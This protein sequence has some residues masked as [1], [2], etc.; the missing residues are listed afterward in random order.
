M[1]RL[2]YVVLIALLF[3]TAC[4]DQKESRRQDTDAA[5]EYHGQGSNAIVAAANTGTLQ[6][7]Q[8]VQKRMESQLAELSDRLKTLKNDAQKTAGT[9]K[10]E[11]NKMI[12]DLKKKTAAANQQLER[13]R[14]ASTD[15]WEE[16]KSRMAAAIDD[17][18]RAYDRAAERLKKSV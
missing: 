1:K 12:K 8:Q 10:T 9:A 18:Q 2:G 7:R 5:A 14:S 3:L 4:G 11:A 17:L 13:F 15:T 6:E 16:A